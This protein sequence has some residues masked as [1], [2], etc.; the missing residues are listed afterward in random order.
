M[1]NTKRIFL[2]FISLILSSLFINCIII[3]SDDFSQIIGKEWKVV[4]IGG[5]E[6]KIADLEN[7]LPVITFYK[8]NKLSGF[9]GCNAFNGTYKTENSHITLDQGVMTKMMCDDNTEMRLL[10][11]FDEINEWRIIEDKLELLNKEKVVLILVL[12]EK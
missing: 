9:T 12:V 6:L 10:S 11:A 1:K 5:Q 2:F 8:N 4:S 7:G 3:Q